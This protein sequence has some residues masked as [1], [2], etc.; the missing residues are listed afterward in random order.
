MPDDRIVSVAIPQSPRYDI[1]VA[2][3]LLGR[4][5]SVLRNLSK[6]GKA[7]IVTD[8][9]LAGTHLGMLESSL[10]AAGFEPVVAT[11]PAGEDHKT[12]ADLLPLYDALLGARI[13][14]STPVLA[15]GGGVVGDMTG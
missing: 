2:P 11:L 13:E 4:A 8:A 12:L 15:L 5:G 6:S 9:H 3:G 1:T 7:A 14:R 10:R